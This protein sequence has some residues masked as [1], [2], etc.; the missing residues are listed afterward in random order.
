MELT[1]EQEK[2]FIRKIGSIIFELQ[3]DKNVL[4]LYFEEENN[5][6]KINVVKRFINKDLN[7][8]FRNTVNKHA[9]AIINN[10]IRIYIDEI[11]LETF[12]SKVQDKQKIKTKKIF[13]DDIDW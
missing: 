1:K 2:N 10:G 6:F 3:K 12:I 4:Y 8:E 9:K 13:V 11:D 7:I 5:V